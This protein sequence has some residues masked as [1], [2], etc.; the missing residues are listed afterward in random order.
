MSRLFDGVNDEVTW[1]LGSV[2][3]TGA[4]T[5]AVIVKFDAA[6]AWQGLVNL[7]QTPATHR[8]GIERYN[9]GGD[10]AAMT[11]GGANTQPS[12]LLISSTDGWMVLSAAR[13]AGNV[14]VRFTKHPIAGASPTQST[15]GATQDNPLAANEILFGNTAGADWFKGR[16]AAVAIWDTNLSDAQMLSLGSSLSRANWLSLT[17]KFLVDEMDAFAT[18]YAGTSTR[19]GLVDTTD[20]AD[21][22]AGWANW[23]GGILTVPFADPSYGIQRSATGPDL[24]YNRPH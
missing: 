3:G 20:D 13:A 5:F 12:G 23:A 17:P 4:W 21:D 11:G 19:T 16:L 7:E 15:S 1:S 6:V 24:I 22:P 14:T 18:D 9:T 8:V 10:L 2:V